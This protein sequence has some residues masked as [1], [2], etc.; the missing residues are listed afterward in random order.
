[1]VFAAARGEEF[2]TRT[3][4]EA[5]VFAHMQREVETIRAVG[6][7]VDVSAGLP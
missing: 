6:G 2:R 7:Y 1:M 4:Y 3:Q 5:T